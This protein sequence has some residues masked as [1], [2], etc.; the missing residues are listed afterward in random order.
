MEIHKEVSDLRLALNVKSTGHSDRR[1][2]LG[3]V[4]N[5]LKVYGIYR[6]GDR[7]ITY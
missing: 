6:W 4:K 3:K 2:G 7:S 1:E 5:N